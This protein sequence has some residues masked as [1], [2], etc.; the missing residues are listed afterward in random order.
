MRIL[1]ENMTGIE[2][3]VRFAERGK[4]TSSSILHM[5]KGTVRKMKCNIYDKVRYMIYLE[6]Q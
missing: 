1:T 5:K 4:G 6:T 3:M 2:L